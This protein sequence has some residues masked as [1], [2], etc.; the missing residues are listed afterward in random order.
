MRDLPLEQ[1]A[2][3]DANSLVKLSDIKGTIHNHSTWSDGANSLEE[4]AVAARD[5]G[6]EYLIICDHSRTAVMPADSAS[7]QLEEQ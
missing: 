7:G 2:A 4:M 3:I 5:L 6:L 1:A